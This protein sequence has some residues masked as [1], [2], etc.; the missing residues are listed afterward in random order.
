MEHLCLN[1]SDNMTL[2]NYFDEKNNKVLKPVWVYKAIMAPDMEPF[3]LYVDAV[4]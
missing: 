3:N 2:S 1:C 4:Q